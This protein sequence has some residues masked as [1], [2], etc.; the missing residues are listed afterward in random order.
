M[1]YIC[2]LQVFPYEEQPRC[3]KK[4]KKNQVFET[5]T[6]FAFLYTK[7]RKPLLKEQCSM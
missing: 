4:Q 7:I 5:K 3:K 2:I 6:S 1:L